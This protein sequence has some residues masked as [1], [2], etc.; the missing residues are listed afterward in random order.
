MVRGRAT[1]THTDS[2]AVQSAPPGTNHAAS[3][4]VRATAGH[5]AVRAANRPPNP[6]HS[7]RRRSA[8]TSSSNARHPQESTGPWTRRS[9]S[10]TKEEDARLE[11]LVK[12]EERSAPSITVTKMWSRVALQL[13]GRTGKQCRERWLNQLKP[14]IKRGSWSEEEERILHEAHAELG[15]KWVAIAE[16]LEGRTD[17]CVKNHWNSM[18]RKKQRREAARRSSINATSSMPATC[19]GENNL[20][21]GAGL[22]CSRDLVSSDQ[23]AQLVCSGQSP[24]VAP[25]PPITM[26][27]R[28]LKRRADDLRA[29]SSPITPQ[30]SAK[31]KISNLVSMPDEANVPSD[32]RNSGE[33]NW[34]AESIERT[35]SSNMGSHQQHTAGPAQKHNAQTQAAYPAAL[36]LY[37]PSGSAHS[38]PGHCS[39][40]SGTSPSGVTCYTPVSPMTQGTAT[41][42]NFRS[43]SDNAIWTPSHPVAEQ[44]A[45][46]QKT[47]S[48]EPS[49][50]SQSHDASFS[51][52][53]RCKRVRRSSRLASTYE[54][55]SGGKI[56]F[57]PC[58]GKTSSRSSGNPLVALAAAASSV[59]PSPLTP[60]SR[61][62]YTSHSRSVSPSPTSRLRGTSPS[63]GSPIC[64]AL[65]P[66][67]TS[68]RPEYRDKDTAG[69]AAVPSASQIRL[70][71]AKV[72]A[73]PNHNGLDNHAEGARPHEGTMSGMA[74]QGFCKSE[75]T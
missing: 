57:S 60:E 34:V 12:R 75:Q 17:N 40:G 50:L 70:A 44:D 61:Y 59:P 29:A 9:A 27:P 45:A 24:S 21:V 15:N 19:R 64:E 62:S 3:N 8:A 67:S 30:R 32:I 69:S 48:R 5:S 6:A 25:V 42:V 13:N 38:Q 36:S 46:R 4:G 28:G 33:G 16:R 37:P 22:G 65:T 55:A 71:P 72:S 35:T 1:S 14:G 20:S 51:D 2:S 63:Q 66:H 41:I 23:N 7:M 53:A 26:L 49:D 52:N 18:L 31:L 73:Q 58:F 10:W 54:G 11:E 39:R 47:C 43:S 68:I 74:Q 56:A